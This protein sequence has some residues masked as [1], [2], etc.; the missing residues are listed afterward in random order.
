MP[1][2]S[3][4]QAAQNRELTVQA[5]AK[6]FRERGVDH[7]SVQDIMAAV[8]LTHGG[9]YRQFASKEA[10]LPEAARYAYERQAAR[11]SKL[12]ATTENHATAQRQFIQSYL[13]AA[14]R[15]HPGKG[16]PIAGL[17]QD[18]ARTDSTDTKNLL[19]TGVANLGTWLDRP[20]RDGLVTA[21]TL[22]GALLV[23]R[24]A[25]GSPLSDEVLERVAAALVAPD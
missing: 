1:R 22:I 14:H 9:F 12:D 21:C 11:L 2:V 4:A 3:K 5:A 7:V 16:C 18:I 10:L 13:S 24:A 20:G 25:A 8:G 23:S 6:L 17:I 15:D 19:T